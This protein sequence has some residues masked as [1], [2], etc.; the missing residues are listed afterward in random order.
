MQH[1][2][3]LTPFSL[4][5]LTMETPKERNVRLAWA[6]EHRGRK[7]ADLAKHLGISRA[8]LTNW[9]TNPGVTPS[10]EHLYKMCRFL[11]MS[12]DWYLN[13]AGEFESS[14]KEPLGLSRVQKTI[15]ESDA[16]S[17]GTYS[18]KYLEV[19]V[20]VWED[21]SELDLDAY[22]KVPRYNVH[23]SAGNGAIVYD[24]EEK[25]KPQTFRRQWVEQQ[26]WQESELMNIYADGDSMEPTIMDHA[27]L[28]VNRGETRI[29]DNRVYVIRFGDAVRVKRLFARLDGG[30]KVVSDNPEYD[31]VEVTPDL[32]EHIQIIGRVVWQ[33]GLL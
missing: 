2:T 9:T 13:G 11:G 28:L 23:V 3:R 29:R 20:Q 27:T 6:L 32:M 17:P 25:E 24:V 31:D 4:D 12:E 21:E 22:V 5:F 19:P 18:S 10:G 30:I 7:A 26:G 33:A 15:L 1:S 16:T 14:K 8:A